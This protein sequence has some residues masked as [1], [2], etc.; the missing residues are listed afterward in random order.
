ME[1]VTGTSLMQQQNITLERK[2]MKIIIV[3]V[4]KRRKIAL[5]V[6]AP[7]S[8]RANRALRGGAKILSSQRSTCTFSRVWN[9]SPA[10]VGTRD[11]L[12]Q[13]ARVIANFGQYFFSVLLLLT[14]V[15]LSEYLLM[16]LTLTWIFCV[17][18]LKINYAAVT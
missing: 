8:G 18:S 17:N 10:S 9:L 11:L 1:L 2:M 6:V 3:R 15:I 16:K 5:H 7:L 14:V 13:T 12:D 4:R